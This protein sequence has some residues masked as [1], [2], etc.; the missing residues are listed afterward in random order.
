MTGGRSNG[1][2]GLLG[3]GV[4][5]NVAWTGVEQSTFRLSLEEAFSIAMVTSVVYLQVPCH[6]HS[7]QGH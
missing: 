3:N 7:S 6:A 2:D 4:D 5:W 1:L